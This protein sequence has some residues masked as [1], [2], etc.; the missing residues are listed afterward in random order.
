RQIQF[1]LAGAQNS[2]LQTVT[3]NVASIT[4]SVQGISVLSYF[5]TDNAGNVEQT[6]T[7]MV[8][9]DETA[10]V[11]SGLPA[12]GCSVWPST[13]QMVQVATVT[14]SDSLSGLAPG[15]FLIAGASNEPPSGP[16]IWISQTSSGSYS[17]KLQ[18]DRS[19]KGIGRVYT[20]TATA[21]DLAGNKTVVKTTCQVPHDQGH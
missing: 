7:L 4:I 21:S 15:T 19:G 10:P 18:A 14:A 2:G 1:V 20:L 6:H 12:S 5:A 17:V 16:E 3:G 13:H 9:I 11:I 8:K